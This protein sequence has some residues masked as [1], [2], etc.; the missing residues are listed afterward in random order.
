MMGMYETRCADLFSHKATFR[1]A[2]LDGKPLE[3]SKMKVDFKLS[4]HP[5]YVVSEEDSIVEKDKPKQ[6]KQESVAMDPD[7]KSGNYYY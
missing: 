5:K 1:W 6:E 4:F 7:H 2:P 3:E